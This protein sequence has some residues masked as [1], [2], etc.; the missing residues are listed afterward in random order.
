MLLQEQ[1]V[2]MKTE[3]KRPVRCQSIP[4]RLVD[5]F[6]ENG[7]AVAKLLNPSKPPKPMN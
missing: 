2:G 4:L 7:E 1:D 3:T 6:I 5:S